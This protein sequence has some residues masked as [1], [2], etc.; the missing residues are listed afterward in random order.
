MSSL[1]PFFRSEKIL[2]WY[3]ILLGQK[4]TEK[5]W[6]CRSYNLVDPW[7]QIKKLKKKIDQ[8]IFYKETSINNLHSRIINLS[9]NR[10]EDTNN[11]EKEKYV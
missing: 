2:T 5:K 4:Y 11:S 9:V 1:V 10:E 6:P 8:Q 3:L 7:H